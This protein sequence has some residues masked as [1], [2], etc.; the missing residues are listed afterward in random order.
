MGDGDPEPG[1]AAVTARHLRGHVCR[2]LQ[3]R[4]HFADG[5]DDL[6][7]FCRRRCDRHDREHRALHRAGGAPLR[8]RPQRGGTN[9]FH[10]HLDYL[11]VDR[12]VHP[13][14]V[15]GR[16][17]RQAVPRIRRHGIGGSGSLGLC[18]ADADT[19]AVLAVSEGAGA[20]RGGSPQSDRRALFRRVPEYLRPRIAVC[21]APSVAD[22]SVDARA[23]R[24]DRLSL[25]HH[26]QGF[27]PRA[28][29]R[30]YFW[31]GGRARG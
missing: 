7:R 11:F 5:A 8:C 30:L 20:A 29:Y 15:H 10:D 22:V 27:F 25:R 19:R 16:H 1:R 24:R 6:G 13:A 12:S 3:P 18:L 23:D 28:G 14:A 9:R 26:S 4:Q 31:P 17:H 21:L 2:R